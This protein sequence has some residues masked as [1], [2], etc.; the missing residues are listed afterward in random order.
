MSQILIE[1]IDAVRNI[2]EIVNMPGVDIAFVATGD[3]ATSIGLHGQPNHPEV[4]ALVTFR[5]L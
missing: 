4:Q 5:G 2:E 3:L 1:H